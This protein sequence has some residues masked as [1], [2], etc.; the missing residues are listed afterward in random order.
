M[1]NFRLLMLMHLSLKRVLRMRETKIVRRALLRTGTW[2]GFGNTSDNMM[3]R[4]LI[5]MCGEFLIPTNH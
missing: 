5:D 1:A 4:Q 3:L 2:L